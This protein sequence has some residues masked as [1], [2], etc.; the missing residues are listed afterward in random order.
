VEYPF[1]PILYPFPRVAT[2]GKPP[3]GIH[4][5]RYNRHLRATARRLAPGITSRCRILDLSID[6][7]NP[8]LR[9]LFVVTPVA[10]DNW[11]H[12]HKFQHCRSA[13]VCPTP[14]P[15]LISSTPRQ[16]S[17]ARDHSARQHH[18]TIDDTRSLPSTLPAR[19]L[20]HPRVRKI[21]PALTVIV[22]ERPRIT[23]SSP[24]SRPS[25]YSRPRLINT[26]QP[27]LSDQP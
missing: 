7:A 10:S 1:G 23:R 24:T 20:D 19:T 12:L 2:I 8:V 14:P 17:S 4:T 3:A 18:A 6:R 22:N 9:Y 15:R 5:W 16:L 27:T 25:V 13:P 11:R 21:P 26:G